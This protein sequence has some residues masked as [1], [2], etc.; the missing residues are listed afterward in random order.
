MFENLAVSEFAIFEDDD[1]SYYVNQLLV[2]TATRS[3]SA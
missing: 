3:Q 1:G 2:D